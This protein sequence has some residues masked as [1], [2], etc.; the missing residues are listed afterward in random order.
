MACMDVAGTS[1]GEGGTAEDG[2]A[3]MASDKFG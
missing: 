1:G 3:E 2:G